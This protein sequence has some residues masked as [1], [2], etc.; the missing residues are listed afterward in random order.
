M[1]AKRAAWILTLPLD[2]F[3]DAHPMKSMSTVINRPYYLSC[4]VLFKANDAF[5]FFLGLYVRLRLR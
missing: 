3:L 5:L 1:F 2:P 4:L